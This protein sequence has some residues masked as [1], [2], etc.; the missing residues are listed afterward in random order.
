MT[1]QLSC[2]V[3]MPFGDKTDADGKVIDFDVIYSHL[4]KN[5]VESL[6]ISCVRCDHIAESGWVHSKM[7]NS[8][9]NSDIAVVDITSLNPNVFYELGVRH[10]LVDHVTVLI[11]RKGTKIPFNIQGMTIIDYN[12]EDMQSVDETKKKI[13]E[14]IQN[15]LKLKRK[16]SPVHDVLKLRIDAEAAQHLIKTTIHRYKLKNPAD[17]QICLITGDI[18]R[19]KNIDIWVNSENTNMQMSRHYD[20]SIS[21]MIRYLGAKTDKAGHVVEDTIADELSKVT[22]PHA[23]VPPGHV[24]VTGAGKLERTHGVKRLFHAAAVIGELGKG[25]RPISDVG[26]CVKNALEMVDSADLADIELK[27]ILF[28]L[29]GTGTG[30][31]NLEEK[32]R[33]LIHAALS[34][35]EA[36]P[37]CRIESVYFLTWSDKELEACQHILEES[38]EVAAA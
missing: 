16:D 8:I 14:F 32:A 15:G 28:P 2:F 33:E 1:R 26:E 19:V 6:G 10:A 17:K 4:I 30:R 37:A 12:H 27:S 34:Y 13:A 38:K 3:I 21:S 11:R 24:I 9:Y 7:F 25:Y 5:T 36:N 35:L 23:H 31:G 22:G 20:R 18:Q 29:I